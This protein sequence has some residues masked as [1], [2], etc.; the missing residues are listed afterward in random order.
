MHGVLPRRV[1]VA[2]SNRGKL[3]ELRRLLPPDVELLTLTD[4]GIEQI[5][6][7][8]T[9]FEENARIKALAA[10]ERGGMVA[11]AD[12]SGLDV[13]A[14]GGA[15]GDYSARY[16]GEDG[17]DER[18]RAKLLAAMARIPASERAA[19]FRCVVAVATPDGRVETADGVCEGRV[20]EQEAGE[21]GFGYDPL[22]VLP[23]GRAMAQLPPEEKNRI[24]H[25]ARAVQAILPRL[26]AIMQQETTQMAGGDQWSS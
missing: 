17:N 5:P 1:V 19:R 25:R 8:G 15:P 7:T 11:V 9:T 21:H 2:T 23:D 4:L 16:A 24:S 20:G 13:D 22:F 6:E 10:A 26:T 12:D 3:A 14:L 18:N